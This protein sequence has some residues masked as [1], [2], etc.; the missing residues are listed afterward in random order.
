MITERIRR[1]IGFAVKAGFYVASLVVTVLLVAAF[2]SRS[3][4]PLQV[5]H[6][7]K[8]PSQ[9]HAAD[10]E[11]M[12][13]LDDYLAREERLFG[14]LDELVYD[15]VDA[16]DRYPFNRYF[17][18]SLV[19]PESLPQNFNRSFGVE[20]QGERRCGALLVHGLTDSPYSMRHL[21]R[22]YAD[23]G[24]YALALRMPGHGTAPGVLASTT[25][26]DWRA[27]VALGARAVRERI[28][29][30]APL[31]LVGYS[32]GGALVLGQ[33]LDALDDP[34]LVRPDGLMLFSP[35]IGVTPFSRFAA[36]GELLS[37]LE[38]FEQF[39]WLDIVPEFD[40][41][42]YN[43]FPKNAG[44]QT[45][46]ITRALRETLARLERQG[47]LGEIPPILT[48]QSLVDATVSMPAVVDTLYSRLRT[49]GSELVLFDL[50]RRSQLEPLLVNDHRAFVEHLLDGP[51]LG[52]DLTLITN[53][54]DTTPE[55]V[56]RHREA[57]ST[58]VLTL[59]VGLSWPPG[60]YSLSHLAIPFS[61]DDEFYGTAAASLA[62]GRLGLGSLSLRGE[63]DV[64]RVPVATLIR[65]RHNPFFEYVATR[66]S[67][68][69][70]QYRDA[71]RPP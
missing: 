20:P 27:A 12:N 31:F 53:R 11:K 15:R 64:T 52:Y 4:A 55:V 14:E 51:T 40:P 61:D 69:I 68:D 2:A 42:K 67:A 26:A 23:A 18:G 38:Y 24:C 44:H 37:R 58:E 32:N 59:P 30:T 43:S 71:Q 21:A 46:V 49:P 25:W 39:A 33:A 48:F 10:I 35:M 5:W 41:F 65:L 22:V 54:D 60:T 56:A 13:G 7:A 3:M 62:A 16:R 34:D 1:L 47:R 29:A 28:D 6:L 70:E 45:F 36:W 17:R 9:F 63:R 19:D 50:N 66:L 8:L 57:G